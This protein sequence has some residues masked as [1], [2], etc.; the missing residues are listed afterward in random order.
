MCF[1][2]M[3]EKEQQSTEQKLSN[4]EIRL[5]REEESRTQQHDNSRLAHHSRLGSVFTSQ[6]SPLATRSGRGFVRKGPS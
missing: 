4:E 2:Q 5:K 1:S 6:M 3:K